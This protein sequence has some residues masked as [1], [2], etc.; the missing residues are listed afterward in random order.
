M[1]FPEK[2]AFSNGFELFYHA[3]HSNGESGDWVCPGFNFAAALSHASMAMGRKYC[4]K[5]QGVQYPN[6]YQLIIG[7]SHLAAKSPTL[8]RAQHGVDFL[9][10]ELDPPE[11]ISVID[12][13]NSV[14]AFRDR[15]ATH[16][17]ADPRKTYGLVY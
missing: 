3:H 13:I 15:F 12:T 11:N 10:S 14:E 17:D 5:E 8:T 9:K 1:L 6:F 16:E 2:Q 7:R 4:V